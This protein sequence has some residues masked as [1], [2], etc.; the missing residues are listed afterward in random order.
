M[1]GIVAVSN[2][3][4]TTVG[5]VGGKVHVVENCVIDSLDAVGVVVRKEWVVRSLD[6]FIDDAVYD[7]QVDKVECLASGGTILDELVLLIEVIEE[8][9]AIVTTVTILKL[10]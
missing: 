10:G 3:V 8:S 1:V 2:L 4:E 6:V 5:H 7:T 9:W